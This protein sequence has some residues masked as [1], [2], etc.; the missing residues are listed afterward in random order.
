MAKGEADG[1][2]VATRLAK[3]GALME[4]EKFAGAAA[5]YR[6]VLA[7]APDA[8]GAVEARFNLAAALAGTGRL[9]E[10]EAGFRDIVAAQ[11]DVAVVHAALADAIEGYRIARFEPGMALEPIAGLRWPVDAYWRAIGAIPV[12]HGCYAALGEILMQDGRLAEA[13]AALADA[14]SFASDL[15]DA[16]LDIGATVVRPGDLTG[17]LALHRR[18]MAEAPDH[19]EM[20]EQDYLDSD[21]TFTEDEILLPDGF[22]VMME[23]ERPIMERSAEIVCH[24]HGDVLNVGFGMA[25][26][27][28]AIQRQGVTG[29]TIIE[30][31]PQV[32]RRAEQWAQDR[33]AVTIVPS[34]WQKA[35][36]RVGPFDGVYF[37]TLMP[38]MIPFLEMM[39]ALL[40]PGGVCLYF[41][42]MIQLEN[43][44]AMIVDDFEFGIEQHAFDAVAENRY[45]RLN[46][47]T[48]DGRYSAPLYIYRKR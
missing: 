31:H 25:I 2:G 7:D 20:S 22:E 43:L 34:T 6:R 33:K 14:A 12:L 17:A 39:P 32:V 37:D 16:M 36:D 8:P 3:A 38:P 35:I 9:G 45:Y 27:D 48:A 19:E 28:S 23:W 47:R 18:A 41:Q 15:P 5:V 29:H 42:S 46:E 30:A 11:P 40:K 24:N 13:E 1:S 21:L 26:V 10:A 4:E 44:D